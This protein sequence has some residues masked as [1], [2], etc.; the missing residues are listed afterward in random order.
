MKRMSIYEYGQESLRASTR[1]Q[2]LSLF[3]R[4]LT[5]RLAFYR[6]ERAMRAKR[7]K[8]AQR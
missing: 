8:G 2:K 1:W 6:T 4:S 7:N 3:I 5:L